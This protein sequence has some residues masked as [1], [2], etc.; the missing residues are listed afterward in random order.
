MK[1]G[2]EIEETMK[3]QIKLKKL[4]IPATVINTIKGSIILKKYM[5]PILRCRR[6]CV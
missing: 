4:K 2:F 1:K 5:Y 3:V 6:Y